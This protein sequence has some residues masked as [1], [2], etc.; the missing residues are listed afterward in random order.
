MTLFAW[1]AN[2]ANANLATDNFNFTG[3]S[4]LRGLPTSLP[5]QSV[6][7]VLQNHL[8]RLLEKALAGKFA[9]WLV[10]LLKALNDRAL[11]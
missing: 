10:M 2:L 5:Q 9:N 8:K 11:A 7:A 1:L 6:S 3:L 4:K